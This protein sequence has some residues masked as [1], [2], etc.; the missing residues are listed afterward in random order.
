[1]AQQRLDQLGARRLAGEPVAR[2]LG[3]K[4]FWGLA[5]QLNSATLVPRPETEALVE[6]GIAEL[7]SH[8][9]PRLLDLGT[10][11]G[12]IPIALLVELPAA[13]AIAVDLDPQAI[14]AAGINARRHRV[15]DRLTLRQG[16]WFSPIERGEMFDLVV[17]NPPYIESA[18]ILEL[19]REVRD[20]DP[21]LALDGGADGLDAYRVIVREAP[22]VLVSG[23]MLAVEIGSRQGRAVLELM[24]RR[25]F[26][27]VAVARDL[28]GL[29]RVVSGRWR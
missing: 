20:H 7:S 3:E 24:E 10:G 12:C 21:I 1:M 23:G 29:D 8:D 13:I 5:F 22:S 2:I 26:S 4:E 15:A 28:S 19:D 27:E 11:S 9:A 14:A 16:S 17:S 6:L 25:G 18:D